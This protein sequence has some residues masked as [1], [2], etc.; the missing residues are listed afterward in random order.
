MKAA[1]GPPF[2]FLLTLAELGCFL[3][4]IGKTPVGA[5]SAQFVANTGK[6]T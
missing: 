1:P 4:A 3:Q 6:G 2:T 5:G